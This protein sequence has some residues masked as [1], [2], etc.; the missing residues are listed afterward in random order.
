MDTFEI[1]TFLSI[2]AWN[3]SKCARNMPK[4]ARNRS[5]YAWNML[6]CPIEHIQ[7]SIDTFEISTFLSILAWNMPK[8][9]RNMPKCARN[10]PKCTRNRSKYA[11][12]LL[13]CSNEHI[14]L[15]IDTFEISTL[16]LNF[17]LEH[18]KMR[19]KQVKICVEPVN[20]FHRTYPTVN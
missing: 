9:G 1:S 15:S 7:L 12:N 10:M 3:I 8:C 16:F 18:A 5:K 14:Q 11:W 17:G 19:K 6:T 4:C 2:L 13:T 20:M